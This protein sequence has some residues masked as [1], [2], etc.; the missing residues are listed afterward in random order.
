[1][2]RQTLREFPDAERPALAGWLRSRWESASG[3]GRTAAEA[4][5]AA[6]AERAARSQAADAAKTDAAAEPSARRL[7]DRSRWRRRSTST[8]SER[9]GSLHE[10]G[11][12]T[13]EEFA[14]MKARLLNV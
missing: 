4:A 9:L 8:A 5:L 1:M 13:D 12:L 11:V 7:P 10:S 2:R 6:R 14:A 3:H